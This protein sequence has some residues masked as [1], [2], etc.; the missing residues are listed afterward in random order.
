[1]GQAKDD[2]SALEA[3]FQAVIA[4]AAELHK[5]SSGHSIND[6]MN[7]PMR[8]IDDLNSQLDNY[9]KS[10]G[11]FRSKR[12]SIFG[13]LKAMLQPI[14]AVGDIV[15][16]AAGE[17]FPAT[18]TIYTAILFLVNAAK[19]VSSNY[20]A[21]FELF[22]L[23][24]AVAIFASFF[25]VIVLSTGEIR[26]G[27]FR[28]YFKS[29]LQIGSPVQSALENLQKL[30]AGE[31]RQ[32]LADTYGGVARIDKKTD[33]VEQIVNQVS[34][35]VQ[36]LKLEYRARINAAHQDTLRELLDPS[37]FPRDYFE[38][39]DRS[40]VQGTGDWILQD[41]SLQSWLDGETQYMWMSGG[42][43]TGK[44]FLATRL[45]SWANNNLSHVAYFYFR[46][47]DPETRSVLQ[48]L[49]DVSYQ[50]SESDAFYAKQ[51]TRSVHTTADIKT[52]PSAFRKLFAESFENDTRSEPFYVF[53]DGLDEAATEE[54][55]EL[56]T[57]LAA[58]MEEQPVPGGKAKVKICLT[59]RSHL[60]DLV[61]TYLDPPTPSR[62]L[63]LV[64]VTPDRVANDV[65]SYIKHGVAH[66]RVMSQV[67]PELKA[68]VIETME[69]R[70]DG[71][72][73]LA[74][75]MLADVNRKRRPNSILE[76]LASFP[77]E[78]NGILG[79]TLAD[80]SSTITDEEAGDLNEVLGW[81]ACAQQALTIE[82]L[83]AV[84]ILEF[85]TPPFR[86]ENS[87]RGQ[88]ASF[89]SVERED[90][91][92]TDDLVRDY[93]RLQRGGNRSATPNGHVRKSVSSERGGVNSRDVSPAQRLAD[94][95]RRRTSPVT[96]LESNLARHPSPSPGPILLPEITTPDQDMEFRSKKSSTTVTFFHASVR[97]FFREG[98]P[99]K[100]SEKT[101]GPSVGF[102]ALA[103]RTHI[104]K[105][106][107]RIF[108]DK[109][110]FKS[111]DLGRRAHS[112]K[113]YAA[114]YWQEHLAAVDPKDVGKD[115]KRIIGQQ[116][117]RMLVDET[118]MS[119]WSLMYEEN[120]EGLEVFN[121]ANI[122]GLRAWI[123]DDDVVS[124]L[125]SDAKKWAEESVTR[126]AS[127]F[128]A[129]GRFYAKA[130]LDEKCELYVPTRLC[131]EIVQSISYLDAGHKWSESQHHWAGV[132]V[133]ERI[134][135][136]T[137]W[138]QY[139][140]TAHWFRR[141]GS[142]Y[143]TLNIHKE[144]LAHY[145]EGLKL[146]PDNAEI[147]GPKAYCLLKDKSYSEAL[148]LGLRCEAMEL[149]LMAEGNLSGSAL[150]TSKWR[151]YKDYSVIALAYSLTGNVDKSIEYFRKA[152]DSA[153]E[154]DMRYQERFEPVIG[155]LGVLSTHDRH[156]EIMEVIKDLSLH[157]SGPHKESSRLV[158]FLLSE[159]DTSLVLESIPKAAC[160]DGQVEFLV[161][162]LQIALKI[163]HDKRDVPKGLFLRIALG[164]TLMYQRETD[165]AIE[166][167]ERISLIEYRSRGNVP[168]RRAHA[169]SFQKLA[170]LY[171]DMALQAGLNQPSADHWIKL[172]EA[173]QSKHRS[174]R[175]KT[176]MPLRMTGSDF[177]AAAVYLALIFRLRRRVREA[178]A[179][180]A[181]LIVESCEILEDND[182]DN[183]EFSLENL[184]RLFVAA[185]EGEDSNAR[186]LAVS[187]RQP[188][189]Q[190]LAG[191][192]GGEGE[193]PIQPRRAAHPEPKLSGIQS[194]DRC[195]AQ[196]LSVIKDEKPFFICR[197][198]LDSFCDRCLRQR[199][200]PGVAATDQGSEGL[201]LGLACSVD[202][203][204]IEVPP[205]DRVLHTGELFVDGQ[206][207]RL[208]EWEGEVKK[209]WKGK[210]EIC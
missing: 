203:D 87:L 142:T 93:E 65:R 24:K 161:E 35:D 207:R 99:F 159:H 104:L 33:N 69:K 128:L 106:C 103:M 80:L 126:P 56:L 97:E 125:D 20:D 28:S 82:Q 191:T 141:V 96:S 129:M 92:T 163:A 100:A 72:F 115:D 205:L 156:A 58:C 85:G 196:C 83:E 167:F 162:R 169:I 21:I 5:E 45:I 146:Q 76:S 42:P 29:L 201:A 6:F 155:F 150:S 152:L 136:A 184:L 68:Q 8:S 122:D 151:L 32:V 41:A 186:A 206:V 174:H 194:T 27:R 23:L 164:V 4:D 171:K 165:A 40:R 64:H 182:L 110:W 144:A 135:N 113:Q 77:R 91:L 199:I 84:L 89:F 43:G 98:D 127:M 160:R 57:Q 55:E 105:I 139:P 22:E 180:L 187:M 37:P 193:S 132:P 50:L 34:Q 117:Y 90:G 47:N 95:P 133:Q 138:S 3:A 59:G 54:I 1:M 114:W 154:A 195:C 66:S 131:F 176:K 175:H 143:L 70:V 9:N 145:T 179:L 26:K 73:I 31:G 13:T 36:E 112:I 30:I 178:E 111:Q 124:G 46:S 102:N 181:A 38:S 75:F 198:C 121:D 185:G 88:Y 86:F 49:R 140:K 172:L 158:E 94:S 123:E 74:K 52:V 148:E 177:N 39:F 12:D 109:K 147:A 149:K 153:D 15:A 188:S 17:A 166:I 2:K 200:K 209:K 67:G 60:T 10:F 192:A 120:D 71:L 62:S 197:Y 189:P 130:W 173:V 107:L 108:N 168:T 18:Q 190:G 116:V 119:D 61:S 134:N 19:D 79:M 25:E 204:W 183:D 16:G 11:A 210:L 51:L 157:A 81:V 202:H 14:Q 78:I 137:E 118:T 53:L 44:S 7:P 101:G 170:S 208:A 48:A 63:T